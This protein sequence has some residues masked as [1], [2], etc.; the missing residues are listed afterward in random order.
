MES[1]E[2]SCIQLTE[3][4]AKEKAFRFLNLSVPVLMGIFIFL[5]PFPYTTAIKEI[6]FYSAIAIVLLLAGFKKIEFSFQSP[7]TLPFILFTLWAFIGLFFALDKEN[8]I[9]DFQTHLLKYLVFYYILINVFATRERLGYLAWV[10]MLS[11]ALVSTGLI[12]NFYGIQG[13]SLSTRLVTG[14]PEIAVNGLGIIAVPASI[15]ALYQLMTQKRLF[16]KAAS[17]ACLFP[18]VM[19]CFLT[20]ARATL[21]AIFL[22]SIILF[23]KNKKFLLACMGII[24]IFAVMT[25]I[26]DRFASTDPSNKL[27]LASYYI[28]YEVIKDYPILG[29]GFGMET[30]GNRK[31]IDLDAYYN[32]IPE[33]YRVGILADPHSMLFSVAVRTGLVGLVLFLFILFMPFRITWGLIRQGKGDGGDSWGRSLLSAWAAVLIIG[34]FEPFFNHFS[35]VVFYTLLAMITSYWKFSDNRMSQL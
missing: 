29:M 27:R 31:F 8:S 24:L 17:L 12:V 3:S 25:P 18:S 6:C 22:A 26:K 7:L 11:S 14:I 19:I 20:H 4:G 10:I 30:F 1:K 16:M 2:R 5:N 15:F 28:N 32:R 23:F 33:E 34:F 9:H 35:E 21:L 13:H